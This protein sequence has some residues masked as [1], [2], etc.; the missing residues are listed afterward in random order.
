M[1]HIIILKIRKNNLGYFQ[2]VDAESSK[3]EGREDMKS[4]HP[5]FFVEDN[6]HG[7]I[8]VKALLL[9]GELVI[10]DEMDPEDGGY[11]QLV[12]VDTDAIPEVMGADN[13]NK[14]GAKT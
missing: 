3:H 6:K 4:E 5:H 2:V 7:D 9:C 8:I 12:P 13:N 10:S 1:S 11:E 14:L